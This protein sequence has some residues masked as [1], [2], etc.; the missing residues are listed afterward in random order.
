MGPMAE[1]S[2][3]LR[4]VDAAQITI[5]V[6]GE[7]DMSTAPALAACVRDHG[8]RDIVLDLAAVGFL[9]A[10]GINALVQGYNTLREAGHRL[11]I[12]GARDNVRKVLEIAGITPM[13]HRDDPNGDDDAA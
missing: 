12:T 1:L 11:W 4:S 2:F 7:V 6:A 5:A 10:S 8:D 3:H 9:D 13:L